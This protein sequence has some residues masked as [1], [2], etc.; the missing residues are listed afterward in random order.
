MRAY[1]MNVLAS[2]TKRNGGFIAGLQKGLKDSLEIPIATLIAN[3][4]RILRVM[5]IFE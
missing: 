1:S 3:K 5:K 4:H 2:R